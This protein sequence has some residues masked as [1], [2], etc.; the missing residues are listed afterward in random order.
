[1]YGSD[2]T[3]PR[4]LCCVT[5]LELAKL[6]AGEAAAI[7]RRSF[8]Q[9]TQIEF[10]GAVD[11]VTE[12]DRAAETRVRKLL[13]EHRPHD[14][15]VGEEEGGSHTDDRTW[16]VDPLDGTVNFVHHVPHVAVSVALYEQGTGLVGV[17]VDVM[18]NE[19]FT[20][21][22]GSGAFLDDRPLYVSRTDRMERSLIGVGFPYDRDE[23]SVEYSRTVQRILERAQGIRRLGSAALDLAYVASGRLE[24]YVEASLQPWDI[25]AGAIL[26]T[27]AGGTVTSE[28]GTHRSITST[29]PVVASNGRIH[30][31]L[32]GFL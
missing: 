31:D 8:G 28:A 2:A 27:E 23:R 10:K 21:E 32:L 7:V 26:I 20:A 5:D 25:A 15:I 17:V 9:T 19:V 18:R 4:R 11:P 14:S 12:V 6:V 30:E 13:T 3:S 24:G 1:M 16:I 22:S 29:G